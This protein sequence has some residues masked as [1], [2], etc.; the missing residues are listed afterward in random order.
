MALNKTGLQTAL[1]KVFSDMGTEEADHSKPNATSE[2]FAKGISEALVSY[3]GTGTVTTSDSGTV[4]A[5]DFE[6]A[7]SGTLA[8]ESGYEEGIIEGEKVI[9]WSGCAKIIKDACDKMAQDGKDGKSVSDDYLAEKL[10]EGI[11]KMADDG[12]VNTTVSGQVTTPSGAVSVLG[13]SAKGT[14]S[15]DSSSV[16]TALKTLFSASG[17]SDAG[18]ASGLATAVDTMYKAGQVSTD[19]QGA[20]AGSSGSGAIA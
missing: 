15:V 13:G 16:E 4:S 18:F 17:F 5:G 9:T 3:V 11:Q 12:E 10:A 20:I 2:F 8:V 7:G 6:G 19:G 1:A 14:I